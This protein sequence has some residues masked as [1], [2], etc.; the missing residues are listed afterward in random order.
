MLVST[1]GA[2]L[3]HHVYTLTYGIN[4]MSLLIATK[5]EVHTLYGRDLP[6]LE[7]RVAA[8]HYDQCAR[9][10][11]HKTVYRLATLAVGHLGHTAGIDHAD[12]GNLALTHASDPLSLELLANG[13]GLGEI[14]LTAQSKKSCF[15]VLQ[16]AHTATKIQHF[17]FIYVRA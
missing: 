17:S 1:H 14:Q 3:G 2:L 16:I 15:L 13:A 5:H 11:A 7:L 4:H 6:G 9:V 8:R 10:L 12:V